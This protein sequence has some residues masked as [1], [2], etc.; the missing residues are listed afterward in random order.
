MIKEQ[1]DIKISMGLTQHENVLLDHHVF[2]DKTS[3]WDF[4]SDPSVTEF[5]NAQSTDKVISEHEADMLFNFEMSLG[6]RKV[7]HS[8]AVSN[9]LTLLGKVGGIQFIMLKI[10]GWVYWL[11]SGNE[12][13][14]QML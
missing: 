11:L 1:P 8:R 9:I 7:L 5:Y 4:W 14:F 10:A 12:L 3:R 6:T 13:A 2:S